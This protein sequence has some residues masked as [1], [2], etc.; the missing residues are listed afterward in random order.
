VPNSPD[1]SVLLSAVRAAP[2]S[3]ANGLLGRLASLGL[4][5]VEPFVLDTMVSI[6]ES[7]GTGE[8]VRVAGRAP[9]AEPL[10]SDRDP[11][12]AALTP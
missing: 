11:D 6:V 10:P 4:R 9:R 3:D 2:A 5:L 7:A 1:P 8:V 12:E